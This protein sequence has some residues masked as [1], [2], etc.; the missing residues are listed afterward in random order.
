QFVAYFEKQLGLSWP[1]LLD[2]LAGG[3]VAVALKFAP[4]PAPILVVIQGKD[5]KLLRR[6]METALDVAAQELTR[7]ESKDTIE[8]ATYGG[9]P[10]VR[11]GHNVFA[12]VAGS[13]LIVS[14][15][16]DVLQ[17]ALNVHHA[18]PGKSLATSAG[19]TEAAKLLPTAPLASLWINL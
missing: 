6:F 5:E 2:R 11:I 7:N 15:K 12:A 14:N 10:T 9:T 8:R 16:K 18:K 1:E 19:V 17:L 3:G 4:D 13:T